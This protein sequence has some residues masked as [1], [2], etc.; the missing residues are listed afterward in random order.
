M[1]PEIFRVVEVGM[2]NIIDFNCKQTRKKLSCFTHE[3]LAS[4]FKNV[5]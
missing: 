3:L 5:L 2:E 4:N 1:L